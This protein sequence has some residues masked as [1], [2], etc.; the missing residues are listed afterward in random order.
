M[1]EEGA[2]VGARVGFGRVLLVLLL[3]GLVAFHLD[4][5]WSEPVHG[6]AFIGNADQASIA[7][8]ARNVSEGDGP[9]VRNLWLSVDD[10][11]WDVTF[12]HRMPV[13]ASYSSW[14]IAPFFWVTDEGRKALLSAASV[15]KL[16][17]AIT[18]A[19]TVLRLR[20]DRVS[21]SAAGIVVLFSPWLIMRVNGLSDIY[22]AAAVSLSIATFLHAHQRRTWPSYAAAGLAA[23][24][25]IGV[26]P[27]FGAVALG[28]L[29][30]AGAAALLRRRKD[31]LGRH[32]VAGAMAALVI[33]P[34]AIQNLAAFGSLTPPNYRQ[35]AERAAVSFATGDHNRAFYDPTVS[36]AGL[37]PMFDLHRSLS[38]LGDY[39]GGLLRGEILPHWLLV[40]AFLAAV[41][42]IAAAARVVRARGRLSPRDV[43][44][45]L[46]IFYVAAALV[47]TFPLHYEARYWTFLVP[48]AVLAV[49]GF[50]L[51]GPLH[52]RSVAPVLSSVVV[53]LGLGYHA[54][55]WHGWNT[56]PDEY[57][58]A[59]AALPAGATVLTPEPWQF[60]YHNR[61][62]SIVLPYTADLDVI[63]EVGRRYDAPYVVVLG[64]E[65]R[66]PAHERWSDGHLPDG[67]EPV[68]VEDDLFIGRLEGVD[69]AD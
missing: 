39:L 60:A 26:R 61:M 31:L 63:E 10:P 48:V 45:L 44:A 13:W 47:L 6:D 41:P 65:A 58:R 29:V 34:W 18:V 5:R 36:A 23:G 43:V 55:T 69:P 2:Q 66:H 52:R 12:P 67:L 4:S 50:G 1:M 3:A 62:N 40:L 22:F 33:A 32:L 24:L 27:L 11:G 30:I 64:G 54:G 68:L 21:A 42:A 46:V 28:P 37:D 59:K 8:A 53:V 35:V 38:Y 51:P 17:M 25:A 57:A 15:V 14:F 20:R 49:F 7:A 16:L 9:V 56:V 19:W